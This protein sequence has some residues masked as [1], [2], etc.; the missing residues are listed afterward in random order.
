MYRIGIDGGGTRTRLVIIESGEELFRTESG[1]INYNSFSEQDIR[2]ALAKGAE[3]LQQQGFEPA[4]CE[5]IGI[6]AAGVSNPK[7]VPFLK[8]VLRD[9]GYTCPITVV[10][11]QE[12]AL[13][14]AC[15]AGPG[16]LLIA[17]TGSVCIAR[18]EQGNHYRTGGYGHII[19]DEGSSY[20]V[21]R[22]ILSAIVKAED[23]RG[24]KT[25][26]KEAVF[27]LLQIETI[28]E[29]IAYIYDKDRTKRDIA[30]LAVCLTE[31][32]IKTDKISAKIAGKTAE[33]MVYLVMAV[34]AK[35]PRLEIP[36]FLEG[37][38]LL[39]NREINRL[40]REG[41]AQRELPVYIATKAHDAAYGATTIS[42]V[43]N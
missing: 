22:D 4:E 1:G 11:D 41:L 33:E 13:A 9:C 27:S 12:A 36:L 6:G 26:L 32:I 31:E 19:D 24:Q 20:A 29:L 3:C 5:A 10:G 18:D 30:A 37:G 34:L 35:L 17:G 38:L 40:F 43:I 8:E 14:G 25:A 15:G 16:I 7:A 23:G 39:K 42:Y 28:P 21:G 2:S